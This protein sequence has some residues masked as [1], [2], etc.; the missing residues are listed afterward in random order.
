MGMAAIL[1]SI[2]N[3]SKIGS[4]ASEEKLFENVNGRTATRTSGRKSDDGWKVT[5]IAHPKHSSGELKKYTESE[6]KYTS[7]HPE[8]HL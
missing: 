6:T 7:P 4:G 5:T 3:L 1:V 2:W 8:K